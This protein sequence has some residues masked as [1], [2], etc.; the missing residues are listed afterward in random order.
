MGVRHIE[1][2]V[3]GAIFDGIVTVYNKRIKDEDYNGI[4]IPT[5]TLQ[6]RWG[7]SYG[8]I[9]SYDPVEM[10]KLNRFNIDDVFH[11]KSIITNDFNRMNKNNILILKNIQE[12]N[13]VGILKEK[14]RKK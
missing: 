3:L 12:I 2:K 10:K 6:V 7:S 8:F 13:R 14:Y 9:K 4:K 5:L 11:I 1:N